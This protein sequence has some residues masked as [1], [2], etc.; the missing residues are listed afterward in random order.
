[1]SFQSDETSS[2]AGD[3]DDEAISVLK[4]EPET[5]PPL[6]VEGGL[7]LST[8][9]GG[10][11][12]PAYIYSDKALSLGTVENAAA[13][14]TVLATPDYDGKASNCGNQRPHS[15]SAELEQKVPVL[16]DSEWTNVAAAKTRRKAP[17]SSI[18]ST[19]SGGVSVDSKNGTGSG[20]FVKEQQVR[21]K[22]QEEEQRRRHR[23]KL[24]RDHR[25][26]LSAASALSTTQ[27]PAPWKKAS[28]GG[29]GGGAVVV[30]TTE[31]QRREV[32]GA[33]QLVARV[34]RHHRAV[35]LAREDDARR[36]R[37]LLQHGDALVGR[38][39]PARALPPARPVPR[40]MPPARA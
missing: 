2:S 33:H 22:Q 1:M 32:V 15:S 23:E 13:V 6:L 11:G 19:G 20:S 21:Q 28:G 34:A 9:V 38:L 12:V 8:S 36:L 16:E 18:S 5:E 30:S 14:A 29:G 27:E 40:A 37:H 10:K 3:K 35:R 39:A 31:Q 17:N 7:I 4:N 25:Y 24:Q 26:G